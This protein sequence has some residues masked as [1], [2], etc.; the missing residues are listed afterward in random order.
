[1]NTEKNRLLRDRCD[2]LIATPGRLIDHME[3]SG[4]APRFSNI[5]TLVLD[6]ADRLLDQ[7][8]SADLH[9]I[10]G[11][12]PPRQNRQSLMFSATVSAEIKVVSTFL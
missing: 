9:K 1:M 6:E 3:S 11:F 2:V 8:F 5:R 12:L 10:L 7:G 4:L